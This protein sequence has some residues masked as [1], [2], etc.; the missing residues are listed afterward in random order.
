MLEIAKTPQG[1]NPSQRDNCGQAARRPFPACPDFFIHQPKQS[2]QHKTSDKKKQNEWLDD[3]HDVPGIPPLRK[4]PEWTHTVVVSE[5][6]QNVAHSGEACVQKQQS[7]MRRK[8]RIVG[9]SPSKTPDK[10]D[11][12]H[13]HAGYDRNAYERVSE[14][15][16]MSEAERRAAKLSNH[17]QVRR[18]RSQRESSGGKCSLAVQSRAAQTGARKEMGDRFQPSKVSECS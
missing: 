4:R 5:I 9:S 11:E 6:Q 12:S 16:M 8:L 3:E 7:P 1:G 18:F 15:A 2:G 17:I 14:A 10:I 13:H